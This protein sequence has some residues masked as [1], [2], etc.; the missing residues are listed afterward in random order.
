MRRPR[1]KYFQYLQK[2]DKALEDP[3]DSLTNF[4]TEIANIDVAL[5][6]T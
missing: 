2:K 3:K 5:S 6:T 1:E 4:Q